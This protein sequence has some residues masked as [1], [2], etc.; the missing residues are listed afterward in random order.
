MRTKLKKGDL[1]KVYQKPITREDYEGIGKIIAIEQQDDETA[2]VKVA[3]DD[4]PKRTFSR[5]L[6]EPIEIVPKQNAAL[7]KL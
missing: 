3:F 4:E 5:L 7:A 1:V 2:R 6:A